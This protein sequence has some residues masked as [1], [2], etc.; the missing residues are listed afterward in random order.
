MS[1]VYKYMRFHLRL[2][3]WFFA[4]HASRQRRGQSGRSMCSREAGHA[5]KAMEDYATLGVS[6][7]WKPGFILL[8]SG[9]LQVGRQ[10]TSR[11]NL[12]ANPLAVSAGHKLPEASKK[13]FRIHSLFLCPPAKPGLAK[14]AMEHRHL[15]PAGHAPNGLMHQNKYHHKLPLPPD[16]SLP[17]RHV[18][19]P[20]T[21]SPR[22][23]KS[24]HKLMANPIT[25]G[26]LRVVH[27]TRNSD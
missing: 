26:G 23:S 6:R 24:K 13:A 10:R 20:L 9:P 1:T 12:T 5:C 16:E 8:F 3:V 18:R 17:F 4:G 11:L 21:M 15:H 25:T 27:C 14:L 7:P 22:R 19:K 2:G